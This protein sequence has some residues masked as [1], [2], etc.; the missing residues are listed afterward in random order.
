[1]QKLTFDEFVRSLNQNKDT[2]HSLLLGAG[3]SVESGILSASDCIWDWKNDIFIS[4]NPSMINSFRNVK[5]DNARNRIQI[6]LDNQGIY[7]KQNT[8][9][10]YSFYAEKALP[11]DEDRRKYFQH[12]TEN[13]KPSLGYHLISMLAETGWIKS[14]WT[15]NFDGLIFK[16]AHQYN[17]TPIEITLESQDRIYRNT[18]NNELLYVALHGDYKYGALKNTV[19]ELDSQSDILIK[20]LKHELSIRN[21]IILGY[22]GRDKSLMTAIKEAYQQPGAGRLYWCGY[23]NCPPVVDDLI[24]SINSFGR[25]AFYIPTDGFDKTMLLISKHC[26][27][28]DSNFLTRLDTLINALGTQINLNTSAFQS[29]QGT[30]TKIVKT[31]IY[32]ISIPSTCYQFEYSLK[33]E[34]KPWDFCKELSKKDIIAVPNKG[35]IYAWGEKKN[36]LQ[37]CSGKFAYEITIIPF[38][39][40]MV[41]QNS[42]FAEMLLRALT[43]LLGEI[44][45][46]SFSKDR[47]WDTQM[48]FL[49]KIDN[50]EIFAYLGIQLSLVIDEDR[51]YLSIAP[52]YHF[53]DSEKYTKEIIKI[54]SDHFNKK[55]NYPK[56]NLNINNYV[57]EWIKRIIKA[58]K[59][60]LQYP[61]KSNEGFNFS[62]GSNS[63][64]VG[65]N[66]QSKNNNIHIPDFINKK[67]IVFNGIESFDPE[68]V[69]FNSAQNKMTNDFHPMRG[70]IQ[71]NP[72]DYTISNKI[73]KPSINVGIICPKT[74]NTEFYSFIQQLNNPHPVKYN[75]DYVIPFPGFFNSFKIGLNLPI[76]NSTHWLELQISSKTELKQLAVELGQLINHRLEQFNSSQ[77]DVVLIYIPKEYEY[78]T[79]YSDD[80]EIFDLHNF[81]KAYAV[82]KGISTQFIREKTL[83]SDMRCQI[84]WS[85]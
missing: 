41:Q 2:A 63:A 19:K 66:K 11:I 37:V 64:L 39:K 71:N 38:S 74:K 49:C 53:K 65:I 34:E 40:Q 60:S 46:F 26:M 32:P 59:L 72:Y 51:I 42:V 6:W 83:E 73:L 35:F 45:N 20:A 24:N 36:I 50:K 21:F 78:L 23:G 70:L 5:T 4:Q 16:A 33:P 3:A 8:D 79:S 12:L 68:L 77:I 76:P 61:I 13:K 44:N 17:F 56:P 75:P 15:T 1:M 84:M 31:N 47:I 27:S 81:V 85:L 67:R 80:T 52:S 9:E 43:S 62:I 48:Q 58:P 54:F 29:I 14:V 28:T 18:N 25:N 30:R 82:Q 7:P 55:I 69:F 22:S 10:E 57:D